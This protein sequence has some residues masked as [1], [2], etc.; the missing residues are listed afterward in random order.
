MA[1]T[2]TT[3]WLLILSDSKEA[4]CVCVC[5]RACAQKAGSGKKWPAGMSIRRFQCSDESQR[6]GVKGEKCIPSPRVTFPKT[7]I[8]SLCIKTTNSY[9]FLGIWYY[10]VPDVL[11]LA[12]TNFNRNLYSDHSR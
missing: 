3:F 6:R 12:F 5:T 8:L 1:V 2:P 10:K 11:L 7:G 4:V 9:V